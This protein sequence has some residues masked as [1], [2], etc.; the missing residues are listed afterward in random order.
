MKL[1]P[2]VSASRRTDLPRF[3]VDY[4]ADK[5]NNL[6]RKSVVVLW[7]KDPEN[8]YKHSALRTALSKHYAVAMVTVTGMGG[9]PIEP[10]VP[11]W[12]QVV[13]HTS[14]VIAFLGNPEAVRV[15]FDP[16]IYFEDGKS[17]IDSFPTVAK[18]VAE[19]GIKHIITSFLCF[20]PQVKKG[21]DE[22]GIKLINPP[23]EK[24]LADLQK[25]AYEA[26]KLG[27]TLY[28]CCSPTVEGVKQSSCISAE[29]LSNLFALDL[30]I[31]KDPSQRKTCNCVISRDI[32][33]YS[34]ICRSGCAY[35][36]GQK[37]GTLRYLK[38][39][40]TE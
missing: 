11:P 37:G 8:I 23:L 21:L 17:N 25:M 39:R 1:T 27:I 19:L 12:E 2:I 28:S 36:Y 30:D 10:G 35:C 32:G 7:T 13:E 29:W 18:A 4:L 5:L 9:W 24:K 34:Q 38:W 40:H 16:L 6:R 15:R 20:Y 26:V 3:Y 33:S 31:R 22:S 14:K